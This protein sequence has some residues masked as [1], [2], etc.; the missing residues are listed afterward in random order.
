M[1]IIKNK[2]YVLVKGNKKL[3]EFNETIISSYYY[4]KTNIL[5]L[6]NSKNIKGIKINDNYKINQLFNF[7][8]N[9]DNYIL[10]PLFIKENFLNKNEICEL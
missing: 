1:I 8:Q 2:I 10:K 6:I 4:S 7:E 5:I 9:S 3:Y